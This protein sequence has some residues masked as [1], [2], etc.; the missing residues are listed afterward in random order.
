M[1]R[2]TLCVVLALVV[3]CGAKRAEEPA[4]E[5]AREPHR[6][7]PEHAEFPTHV[8]LPEEV[9]RAAGVR[10]Q[11]VERELLV[12]TIDLPGELAV[13]PDRAARV[14][15]PIPG[16]IEQVSFKEGQRV[17]KGDLLLT[18]RV[19]ELGKVRSE[20]ASTRA[21]AKAARMTA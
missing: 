16:R 21:Q 19:P 10:T 20:L 8:Q 17:Q 1:K 11:K 2:A 9:V 14:A 12:S 13:D 15:S 7:E 18:I 6:D 3:S 5:P 4:A